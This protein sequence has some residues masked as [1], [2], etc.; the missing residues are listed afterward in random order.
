MWIE[1]TLDAWRNLMSRKGRFLLVALGVAI[2]SAAFTILL[3]IGL[4]VMHKSMQQFAAVGVDVVTFQPK[5]DGQMR[6]TS[7]D[8][9]ALTAAAIISRNVEDMTFISAESAAVT[10]G[11]FREMVSVVGAGPSIYSILNLAPQRGRLLS[12]Y[13]GAAAHA[14]LGSAL[15][16]R[17]EQAAGGRGIRPGSRIVIADVGFRVV[18]ILRPQPENLILPF[19][20]SNMVLIRPEAASR[21]LASDAPRIATARLVSLA[22]YPQTRT[23]I[24]ATYARFADQG[25]VTVTSAEQLIQ[26]M[27][28]QSKLIAS[29]LIVIGL[30]VFGVAGIGVM[31]SLMTSVN[32]RVHEIGVRLAIGA[33]PLHIVLLFLIE[34]TIICLAGGVAGLALG[35]AA[36]S[37]IASYQ[38][39]PATFDATVIL[40]GLGVVSLSGIVFGLFPALKAA[41][42]EP[43]TALRMD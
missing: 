13:D 23:V 31:N 39:I 21:F 2:G 30:V 4:S 24:E 40:F 14:V 28:Q 1:I 3:N 16:A 9:D 37:V 19:Q 6:A 43:M 10:S 29:F 32:E 26:A 11:G 27:T 41:W 5:P 12:A 25:G 36:L 42:V 20:V 38:D 34:A 8:R 33:Q 15:A 35:A 18:G 7:F 22:R 17:L